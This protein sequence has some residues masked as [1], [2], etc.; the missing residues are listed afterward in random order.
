MASRETQDLGKDHEAFVLHQLLL[1]AASRQDPLRVSTDN[2]VLRFSVTNRIP[3][4]AS[5]SFERPSVAIE[6]VTSMRV[7]L[8]P[9]AF[10]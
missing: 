7:V 10:V 3:L 2:L 9:P 8:R 4:V 1:P 6:L 5:D